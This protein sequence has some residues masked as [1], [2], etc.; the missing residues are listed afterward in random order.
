MVD[1]RRNA[2][3]KAWELVKAI[4]NAASGNIGRK[5]GIRR[6]RAVCWWTP[7]LTDL[8]RTSYN[9]RRDYQ[10]SDQPPQE[11]R[12]RR[13]LEGLRDGTGSEQHVGCGL[14]LP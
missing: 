8:K 11:R 6:D 9:A 5:S 7:T 13:K 14:S 4:P 2:L 3:K 10:N 12:E 1:T